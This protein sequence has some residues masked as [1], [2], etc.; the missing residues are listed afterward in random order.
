M[1]TESIY[2]GFCSSNTVKIKV[3]GSGNHGVVVVNLMMIG[4]IMA[5]RL[6]SIM[7]LVSP[8]PSGCTGVHPV[9]LR[10]VGSMIIILPPII[11]NIFH[12]IGFLF[13]E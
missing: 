9:Y 10:I 3:A 4:R 2:T 7:R 13:S 6:L 11:I 8:K 1:P 5:M 12:D